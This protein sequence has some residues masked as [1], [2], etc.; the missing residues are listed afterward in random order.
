VIAVAQFQVWCVLAAIR[1]FRAAMVLEG[2][3]AE[4]PT[5]RPKLALLYFQLLSKPVDNRIHM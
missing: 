5:T 3:I 2:E 4:W 1:T